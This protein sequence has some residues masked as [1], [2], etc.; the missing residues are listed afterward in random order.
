MGTETHAT[1]RRPGNQA[2]RRA[3]REALLGMAARGHANCR[4]SHAEAAAQ[5]GCI[6]VSALP[7]VRRASSNSLW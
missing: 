3:E 2:A 1:D 5:G 4:L 7:E 6:G